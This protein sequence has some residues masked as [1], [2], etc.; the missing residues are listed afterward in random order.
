MALILLSAGCAINA[1]TRG[2]LQALQ[3]AAVKHLP[4]GGNLLI[5]A[6]KP[7]AKGRAS[8]LQIETQPFWGSATGTTTIPK[9]FGD[10]NLLTLLAAYRAAEVLRAVMLEEDLLPRFGS[11][12]VQ[13]RIGLEAYMGSSQ[14][15]RQERLF[16]IFEVRVP[17]RKLRAQDWTEISDEAITEL[18]KVE[19][20]DIHRL[21]FEAPR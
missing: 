5:G 8:D 20:N 10:P 6:R 7:T 16:T 3:N 14:G 2:R 4:P 12:V 13:I 21:K 17:K 18:W 1:P 9:E 19:A 11:L 15:V